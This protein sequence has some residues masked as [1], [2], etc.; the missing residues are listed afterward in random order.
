MNLPQKGFYIHYKHDPN[1]P[2]HN[3]MYEVVGI[4]R[5]TEDKSL[6]VLYRPLYNSEWM[7]PASYQARPLE[8]FLENVEKGGAVIPRFALITDP[9]LIKELEE[10]RH[11]MYP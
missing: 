8:M 5:D 11:A 6:S 9:S 3:Y 10:V 2:A 1:G 7:P 4:A